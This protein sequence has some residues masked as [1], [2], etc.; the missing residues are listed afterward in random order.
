MDRAVYSAGKG[1]VRALALAMVAGEV[2]FGVRVD[3]ISSAM[4]KAPWVQRLIEES[5]DPAKTSAT[6]ETPQPLALLVRAEEVAE[7]VRHLAG[8]QAALTG[9][10][11]LL[12]ADMTSLHLT[13]R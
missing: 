4:V 13:G 3:C 12:D 1:A 9:F 11:Y 7:V 10:D 5:A 6:L 2:E 8:P